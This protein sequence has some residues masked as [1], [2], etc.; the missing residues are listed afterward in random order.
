M[1]CVGLS[2]AV[3][4]PTTGAVPHPHHTYLKGPHVRYAAGTDDDWLEHDRSRRT[5]QN[6]VAESA[7]VPWNDT[8][9]E[10][11]DISNAAVEAAFVE[12]QRLGW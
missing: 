6:L 11:R 7:Q 5:L 10:V 12:A 3:K 8:P 9:M 2:A 1:R 4:E